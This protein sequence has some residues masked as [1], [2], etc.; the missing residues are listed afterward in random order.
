MALSLSAL[1]CT[2][3][4]MLTRDGETLP[5]VRGRM[6]TGKQVA[7]YAGALPSDPARLLSPA[8]QGA[9]AWLDQDFGL[10]HFAPAKID[11]QPGFGPP[12]IR[13]DRAAEFLSGDY[14]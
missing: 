2:V 3:E 5:A 1:R 9:L 14:L 10:M 8:R 4:E 13:L 7:L 11:L 12:H 6:T